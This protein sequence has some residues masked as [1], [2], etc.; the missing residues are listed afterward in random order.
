MLAANGYVWAR[1]LN[2][3]HARLA[4]AQPLHGF[5]FG[6][7][8]MIPGILSMP[9]GV[10]LFF[11]FL[12]FSFLLFSFLFFSFLAT[13]LQTW[14]TCDRLQQLVGGVHVLGGQVLPRQQGPYVV[15]EPVGPL[16]APLVQLMGRR[17]HA[18]GRLGMVHLHLFSLK[19]KK[20]IFEKIKSRRFLTCS[21][22][23]TSLSRMCQPV[24]VKRQLT[25]R[26]CLQMCQGAQAWTG[27]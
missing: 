15:D 16:G 18:D 7:P 5:R 3:T 20:T 2:H 27:Q 6:Q 9:K 1:V 26:L 24:T 25:P 17:Q 12:L 21:G 8:G 14:H 19:K 4:M 22:Q 11:S 10:V 23:T 13:R